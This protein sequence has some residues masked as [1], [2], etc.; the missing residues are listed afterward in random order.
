MTL[1][2]LAGTGAVSPRERCWLPALHG[3]V[4]GRPGPPGS[5][6]LRP[7]SPPST[8]HKPQMQ[9]AARSL[10]RL[11]QKTKAPASCDTVGSCRPSR[12]SGSSSVP[13]KSWLPRFCHAAVGAAS[14]EPLKR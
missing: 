13:S 6:R 2:V 9:A 12:V 11:D 14:T 3:L 5:S 4:A 7:G 1:N 10:V 8:L